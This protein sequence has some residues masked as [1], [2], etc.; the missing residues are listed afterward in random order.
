MRVAITGLAG[1]GKG[2]ISRSLAVRLGLFYIDVGLVFRAVAWLVLNHRIKHISELH[3]VV[4]EEG[5]WCSWNGSIFSVTISGKRIDH[6]LHSPAISKMTAELA[7]SSVWFNEMRQIAEAVISNH[8]N[9]VADGRS[10]GNVILPKADFIFLIDASLE[11]RSRR[12]FAQ[13]AGIKQQTL[14]QVR[15]DIAERDKKDVT[16]ANDPFA[17]PYG[18]IVISNESGTIDACVEKIVHIVTNKT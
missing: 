9:L 16:R 4:C 15:T 6:E 17:V 1:S 10:V 8:T 13:L 14:D 7:G 3:R 2:A 11:T 5:L 12:R 18:A